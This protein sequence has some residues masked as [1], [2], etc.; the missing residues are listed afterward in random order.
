M[1]CEDRS[2][3]SGVR[4]TSTSTS[5]R[6]LVPRMPGTSRS[7]GLSMVMNIAYQHTSIPAYGAYG[8]RHRTSYEYMRTNCMTSTGR[9]II[10]SFTMHT[11]YCTDLHTGTTNRF[12][13]TRGQY[14]MMRAADER[15]KVHSAHG[16]TSQ[17][18]LTFIAL[19]RNT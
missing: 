1:R 15:C 9:A 7:S 4:S 16:S 5:T 8:I 14:S 18:I 13:L 3:E 11:E 19:H 6:V 12:I 10:Q 17:Q 2:P